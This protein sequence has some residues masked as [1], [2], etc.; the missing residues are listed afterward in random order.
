MVVISSKTESKLSLL[1]TQISQRTDGIIF[2][3]PFEKQRADENNVF[4]YFVMSVAFFDDFHNRQKHN[5]LRQNTKFRNYIPTDRNVNRDSQ[6]T[7]TFFS[8]K[9]VK[10]AAHIE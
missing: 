9:D 4:N 3:L 2:A 8:I 10:L 7:V 5:V 6:V 1:G